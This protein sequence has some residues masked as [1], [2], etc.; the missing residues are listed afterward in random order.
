MKVDDDDEI[1]SNPLPPLM[2]KSE[3]IFS[4]IKIVDYYAYKDLKFLTRIVVFRKKD[5]DDNVC[6]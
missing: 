3:R 4:I 1:E 2:M 6:V 5:A